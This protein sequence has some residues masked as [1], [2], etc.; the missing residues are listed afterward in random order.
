MV[1]RSPEL[2]TQSPPL[3]HGAGGSER[4]TDLR[5]AKRGSRHARIASVITICSALQWEMRSVMQ[6]PSKAT[7]LGTVLPVCTQLPVPCG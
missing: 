4:T 3:P 1:G 7:Q 2:E 5:P 6:G